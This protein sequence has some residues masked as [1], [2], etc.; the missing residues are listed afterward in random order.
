VK[1]KNKNVF[2]ELNQYTTAWKFFR[3]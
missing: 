3:N 2:S 1:N